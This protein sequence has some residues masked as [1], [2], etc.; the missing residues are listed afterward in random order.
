MAQLKDLLVA[1]NSRFIG[2]SSF[3]DDVNV[4]GLLAAKGGLKLD[5][6]S[7]LQSQA[8]SKILGIIPFDSTQ[9]DTTPGQV[10]WSDMSNITIG[11]ANK[12]SVNA[13][14]VM[15]PVYFSEGVPVAL[16]AFKNNTAK[17]PLGWT[18]TTAD[19]MAITSNTL[20]YWNGAYTGTSSNLTV[21]GTVSTGTWNAS[22][23]GVKYGGT[24]KTSHTLNYIL[25][26]NGEAEVKNIATAD[27]AFYATSAGGAA[28]FGTLPVAQ[29]GTGLKTLTSGYALIG[30]GTSQV[31]LRAITNNTS[32]TYITANTNL[33]TANTLANW[34]GAYNSSGTSKIAH[35]GTVTTGTWNASVIGVKYGGTGKSS[36]TVNYILAGNGEAEVK[37]IATANGAF[38]AT[39]TGGAAQFGTLPIGQ[40]GTGTKSMTAKRMVYTNS[41]GNALTA[42]YHYVD[43]RTVQIA[44]RTTLKD[45]TFYV[46]VEGDES[47]TA[48][49]GTMGVAKSITI[50]DEVTMQ[51]DSTLKAMKFVF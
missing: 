33:I 4:S 11:T 3:S 38:Y 47:G 7:T 20:A 43:S 42:G 12:L 17:G 44:N 1:G 28:Q 30:N 46:G 31:S 51:Y 2:E 16:T 9:P 13:G 27:G 37:N 5:S 10:I 50:A 35:L 41:S 40:G 21:L 6:S 22:T 34:N 8:V 23:I 15:Q 36:H 25:A 39:S 24:G 19:T 14:G 32:A 49:A 45:Y 48:A 18:S 29:G 26:G